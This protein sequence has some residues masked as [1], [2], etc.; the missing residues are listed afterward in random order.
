[1]ALWA[2]EGVDTSCVLR[3]DR[4]QTGVYFVTHDAAGHHFLHYRT[5]SAASMYSV[6]DVPAAA[7]AAARMLYVSGISQGISVAGLRCGVRS[8]RGCLRQGFRLHT[9]PIT[10]LACGRRRGQPP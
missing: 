8:D 1:M 5:G 3:T 4:Y 7:I 2:R 10:G 6:A 9:I